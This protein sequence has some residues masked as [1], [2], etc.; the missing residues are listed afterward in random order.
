LRTTNFELRIQVNSIYDQSAVIPFRFINNRIEILLITSINSGK[1]IIPKGIIE[2]NLSAQE[3]A[4]KEAYEEAG[5][6]GDVIDTLVGEYSYDKWGG[7]CQVQVY[8]LYVREIFDD[9]LE[10]GE[11]ERRWVSL[12]LAKKL[13]SKQ[14][15]KKLIKDFADIS[16][17]FV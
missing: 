16:N 2:E 14:E 12:D 7:T 15:L 1:W 3:S 9:W 11:R 6:K 13:V 8:P 4:A 17:N 10:S 5:V